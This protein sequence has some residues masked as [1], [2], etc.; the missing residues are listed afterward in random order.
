MRSVADDLRLDSAH[1]LSHLSVVERIDLA[2]RLG[3]EDVVF[4]CA[5]Q[6]VSDA[7]ARRVLARARA[8]GRV[9]S[10]SNDRSHS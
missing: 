7:E 2:L 6:G 8:V 5:A 3:D 10:S 9:P 4:Y 1:R